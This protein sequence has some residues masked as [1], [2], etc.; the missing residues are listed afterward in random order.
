MRLIAN[1]I[2]TDCVEF[3]KNWTFLSRKFSK[4]SENNIEVVVH[5]CVFFSQN[6]YKFQSDLNSLNWTKLWKAQP[7]R[8]F[9]AN[10][11]D[12]MWIK[13]DIIDVGISHWISMN[14][15]HEKSLANRICLR[16]YRRKN[17]I[18]D[19]WSSIHIQCTTQLSFLIGGE[20]LHE[21]HFEDLGNKK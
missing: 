12:K 1:K 10:K 14:H 19:M 3:A 16:Y 13:N 20:S 2:D 7:T 8:W 11:V 17:P 5:Y 15:F 6:I 9:A 18:A 4:N 21:K